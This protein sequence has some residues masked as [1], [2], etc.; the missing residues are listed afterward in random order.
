[1]AEPDTEGPCYFCEKTVGADYYC[2]GC[3]EHICDECTTAEN[4]PLGS[5]IP[6]DHQADE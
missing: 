3:Q 1:M 2:Y 6:E 4:P 5:H